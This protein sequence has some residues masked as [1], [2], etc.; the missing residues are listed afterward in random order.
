MRRGG[1]L[2]G[3]QAE[4]V[5]SDL[6]VE[7]LS[8]L[9][10]TEQVDVLAAVV[11]LCEAP[12][13]KHP[14]SDSLAGWNTVEVLNGRF[15]VVF[16]AGAP[17][18]VGLVEVL[19]L[20]PRTGSEV[21]DLAA[22]VADTGLLDGDRVTQVWEAL[23]VL[24]VL[25]ERVGLDGWDYAPPPAPEG[26][27]RSVVAAGLI[28]ESMARLLSQDEL[29]AAMTDGWGPAGPDP[30][31]ALK[32]ALLRARS[33]AGFRGVDV[34]WSD[35]IRARAEPRCDVVLPRARARCIRRSGHPGPHRSGP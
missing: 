21:Y 1:R 12:A 6:F 23:A 16:R 8:R 9:T 20:G 10:T 14:L 11:G 25:A 26:Q 31:R 17:G 29:V 13:G 18:G 4:I 3:D 2:P 27:V 33:R 30:A 35:V 19:C 22:A 5:F 34:I 28:E 32:A 24:D 15:R 7:V